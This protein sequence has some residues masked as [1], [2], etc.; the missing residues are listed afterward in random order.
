MLN[1]GYSRPV[2][3]EL[4]AAPSCLILFTILGSLREHTFGLGYIQTSSTACQTYTL[5]NDRLYI[6][7]NTPKHLHGL[8]TLDWMIFRQL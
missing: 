6:T 4:S 3:A 5:N 7:Y 8:I 1:G 2:W